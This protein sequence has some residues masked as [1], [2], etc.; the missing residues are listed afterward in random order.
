M[1]TNQKESFSEAHKLAETTIIQLAAQPDASEDPR[2][3]SAWRIACVPASIPPGVPP[4]IGGARDS[5]V[6]LNRP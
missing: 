5:R 2:E 6:N 1:R 4:D 3:D